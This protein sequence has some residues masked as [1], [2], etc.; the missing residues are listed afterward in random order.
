[1]ST[2]QPPPGLPNRSY[3]R[4]T[5]SDRILIE[6]WIDNK[7][8]P[9]SVKGQRNNITT[10]RSECSHLTVLKGSPKCRNRRRNFCG[11]AKSAIHSMSIGAIDSVIMAN[12]I[13]GAANDKDSPANRT[14]GQLRDREIYHKKRRK[15]LPYRTAKF[16]ACRRRRQQRHFSAS[17]YSSGVQD[18]VVRHDYGYIT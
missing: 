1:M 8:G 4:L 6:R 11:R 10:N 12:S 9:V 14:R 15:S 5:K 3:V 2:L 7:L 17:G 16:T 18:P 13:L